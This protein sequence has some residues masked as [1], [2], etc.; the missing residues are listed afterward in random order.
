MSSKVKV[1]RSTVA[2]KRPTGKEFGELW[3]NDKDKVMGY[4]DSAGQPVVPFALPSDVVIHKFSATV[5]YNAGDVVLGP[6]HSLWSAKAA[7]PAGAWDA[8]KWDHSGDGRF[9]K[10][11]G[12]TM[13]GAL[14]LPTGVPTGNQAVSRA[15][16]DK[17]YVNVAGDTM[18]GPLVLS[19]VPALAPQAASRGYVDSIR[20]PNQLRVALRSMHLMHKSIATH[21]QQML[22]SAA[23]A[24]GTVSTVAGFPGGSAHIGG[25][26]MADGRVF[27]V[28]NNATSASIYEDG[29]SHP[30][31]NFPFAMLLGN[32]INKL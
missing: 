11:A 19:G 2:G 21:H 28:P 25:V 6:D 27:C 10:L 4:I 5:A 29:C 20:H 7:I 16:G 3:V 30:T 13:T 18:T 26:L 17:L 15:E 23:S 8:T 1:L 32:T 31:L 24:T 22:K 12:D 14:N 9:V